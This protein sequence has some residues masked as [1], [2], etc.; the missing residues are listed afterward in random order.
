MEDCDKGLAN[1]EVHNTHCVHSASHLV[2]VEAGCTG[3]IGFAIDKPVLAGPSHFLLLPVARSDFQQ[4]LLHG[5]PRGTA[6]RTTLSLPSISPQ[7]SWGWVQHLPFSSS[8]GTSP[9]A[10]TFQKWYKA[11]SSDMSQLPQHPGWDQDATDFVS[12][13]MRWSLTP[14]PFPVG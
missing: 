1:V 6:G 10:M 3:C 12:Q 11:A 14:Y 7:P 2:T 8:S 5:L 9:G 13:R 4:D